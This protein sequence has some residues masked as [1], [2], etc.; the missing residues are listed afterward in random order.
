MT[1]KQDYYA[2]LGVDK[3]TTPADIKKAYRK[4]AMQYHPDRTNGDDTKFKEIKE[5]YEVLADD[6]KRANYDQF[7]HNSPHHHHHNA[8]GFGDIFSHFFRQDVQQS[9]QVTISLT[10]EESYTGCIKLI[11]FVQEVVCTVCK[12]TGAKSPDNVVVCGMC[13]G[14]GHVMHGPMI[15][16]C[17][18]CNGKGKHITDSC[19]HCHGVGSVKT[20]VQSNVQIPPGIPHGTVMR[21]GDLTMIINIQQHATYTRNN[22]DLHMN[23][24]VDAIDAMLG[25]STIVTTLAGEQLK[26]NIATGTQ[27]DAILKLT[28]KGIIYNNNTGHILCHVKIKINTNLTANQRELLTQFKL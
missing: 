9:P 27:P 2:T 13:N 22:L 19:N 14:S 20:P 6:N 16:Q 25:T 8:G 17:P 7:G 15:M 5:A 10:L 18:H 11:N 28:N 26:L 24:V 3:S 21:G 23:I 12:G 4:L 1:N